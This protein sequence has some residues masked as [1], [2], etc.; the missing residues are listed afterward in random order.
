MVESAADV[1]SPDRALKDATRTD[2]LCRGGVDDDGIFVVVEF[3]GGERGEY[4]GGRGHRCSAPVKNYTAVVV[5][6]G[7]PWDAMINIGGDRVV[8]CPR[9]KSGLDKNE[10]VLEPRCESWKC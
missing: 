4:Y 2:L 5:A 8:A 7:G 3:S 1:V 10:E 6:S 9:R